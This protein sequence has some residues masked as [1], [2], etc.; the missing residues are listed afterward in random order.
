MTNS[1]NVR[2]KFLI[3]PT[4]K[5]A[6]DTIVFQDLNRD[7][8]RQANEPVITEIG[9]LAPKEE[10]SIGL[11]MKTSRSATDGL[12]GSAQVVL[13]S[14]GDTIRSTS[15]S[16]QFVY[17][18][19]VL[20]MAMA[21]RE[22]RLK[23]GEVASFDLT[24]TNR[25]SNLARVVELQGIW[26]DQLELIAAEP[27]NSSAGNGKILWNFKELGAGEKRTIKV[28][29]RVK[30]GIGVGTSIQVKNQLSYEDQLGNRY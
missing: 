17:S 25:G 3:A 9:P 13:S 15:A 1:G 8:V 30:A 20:Q 23:P 24:I 5:G 14:E 16:V 26:P 21:A 27:S 6:Q 22:G 12:Q 28:S 4:V 7:G 19:P 11:E 2:E 18:R 10:A 29:F